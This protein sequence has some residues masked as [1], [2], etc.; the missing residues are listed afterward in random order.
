MYKKW[1]E[2]QAAKEEYRQVVQNCRE[3]VRKAKA[4]SELRLARDAKSNKKAF[5]R[6]VQSKRQ[7]KE[8]GVQWGWQ[9]D[10]QEKAEVLS[11]YYGSVF[12][13]KKIYD[14]PDEGEVQAEGAG[15][16]LKI[17][18]QIGLNEFKSPGPNELHPSVI[19]QLAEELSEPLCI[20]FEKSWRTGEVPDDWRKANIVPIFK[21]GKNEEPGN[22][23]PVSLTLIPGKILEHII[24]QS[25]CKYL[26]N[27]AV[28]TRSQHGFHKNKP[29]RLI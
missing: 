18:R 7:R 4:G 10:D 28:I 2:G 24:K 13:Q 22:Y 14:L 11:S 26:E 29:S 6:Y 9:N 19:K 20:I 25:V 1:K 12:S 27:N 17:D 8:A 15:L 23:R 16:Q 5:F 21:K 3:G